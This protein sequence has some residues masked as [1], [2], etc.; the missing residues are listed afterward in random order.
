[1][2]IIGSFFGF[3]TPMSF[4]LFYNRIIQMTFT[5]PNPIEISQEIGSLIMICCI[6]IDRF[7]HR[8]TYDSATVVSD[9]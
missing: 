5:N 1:M 9:L 3:I 6:L 7:F 4:A 8:E 2:V